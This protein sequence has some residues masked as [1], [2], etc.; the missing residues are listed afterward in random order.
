MPDVRAAAG[1]ASYEDV[2]GEYYEPALHPTCASLRELSL[3]YML[4]RM[5]RLMAGDGRLVEIGAIG[6]VLA[7]A[8][9]AAGVDMSRVVLIDS[10][11][12]MLGH[13]SAWAAR[14]ARLIEADAAVTGLPGGSAG[15]VV[16]ALGD[17]YNEPAFWRE[18][19]RILRP[20]GACLFTA[21]SFEW[22]SRFRPEGEGE[23]AEFLRRDG[24]I[25]L[26][27]SNVPNRAGQAAMLAAA[28]LAMDDEQ[29]LTTS[30]LD[31][32]PAP[33]LLCVPPG[34]PVIYGFMARRPA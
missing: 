29:G 14:G 6:S 4:P 18:V 13:S 34:T 8:A 2:A 23:Q 17:P 24:A 15:L 26:M 30:A 12:A 19:A 5:A 20:N 1:G 9:A 11:P 28:G 7:P 31:L 3:N 10:S 27:K 21:P 25:L 22:A 16:A 33:K 32:A